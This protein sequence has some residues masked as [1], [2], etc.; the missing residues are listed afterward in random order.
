MVDPLFIAGLGAVPGPDRLSVSDAVRAGRYEKDRA[1]ADGYVSVIREPERASY[2]MGLAAAKDALAEAGLRGIDLAG[3]AYTSI[4]RHGQPRLW[5]PA[6]WIQ[7]H[8]DIGGHVPALS[9]NQGCNGLL[10]AMIA[11]G[12][13]C[14]PRPDGQLLLVGADRFEASGFDRWQSDYGLLYGDAAAGVVLSRQSGFARVLHLALDGAPDLEE[15]H[16]DAAPSDETPDSWRREYDVRRSKKAFLA[17][18]GHEGFAEPLNRALDRLKTGLLS[19]PYW[20]GPAD[21][22]FTP[23]VG[24]SVR[25]ATY[26]AIFGA[27]GHRSGW[28]IGK[29]HGHLGT[30]DGWVGLAEIRAKGLL[31]S[32]DRVLIVSAGV[33]FSC[34]VILLEIL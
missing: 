6:S 5:A 16:R 22:L 18:H 32:G 23:F 31:H 7:R 10:Q 13:L 15:L 9:V 3:L 2:E 25:D 21:W 11:L 34:G 30:T 24:A 14:D 29:T 27:L 1:E 33:G 26:E 19:S 17:A 28:E 4:H 20:A 12:P 8:L